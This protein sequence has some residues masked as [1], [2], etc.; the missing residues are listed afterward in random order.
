MPTAL[1]IRPGRAK[2][3]S[4]MWIAG[5]VAGSSVHVT[6]VRSKDKQDA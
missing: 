3:E 4:P 5:I 6:Q 2:N 1:G